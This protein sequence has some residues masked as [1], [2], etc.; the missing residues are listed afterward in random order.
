MEAARIKLKNRNRIAELA[1]KW[2]MRL[3]DVINELLDKSLS[4]YTYEFS[5]A[6]TQWTSEDKFLLIKM[7]KDH[8]SFPEICRILERTRSAIMS[9][10]VILG[11]LT[12][13]P[14]NNTYEKT[15]KR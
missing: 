6:G 2:D 14:L 10:L 7:Y 11:Y 15:N 4:F 1:Q 8:V 3:D 5:K 9:R 13:D 12:Y